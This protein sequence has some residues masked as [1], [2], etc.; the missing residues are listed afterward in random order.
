MILKLGSILLILCCYKHKAMTNTETKQINYRQRALDA[1]RRL[2]KDGLYE[3][4]RI[5]LSYLLENAPCI[6]VSNRSS[7]EKWMVGH[8]LNENSTLVITLK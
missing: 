7:S 4:A 1:H 3:P 2:V 8:Y 5:L 6:W